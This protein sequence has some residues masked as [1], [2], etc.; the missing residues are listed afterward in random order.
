MP[1][2]KKINVGLSASNLKFHNTNVYHKEY[3][4]I[5]GEGEKNSKV[6]IGYK[7]ILDDFTLTNDVYY[8]DPHNVHYYSDRIDDLINRLQ[9]DIST[10]EKIKGI[11]NKF[12]REEKLKRILDEK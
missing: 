4:I 2:S 6:A 12:N 1:L 3:D 11:K 10:S 5:C 9:K 8:S 7:F